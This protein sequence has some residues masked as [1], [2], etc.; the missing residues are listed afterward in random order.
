MIAPRISSI[1]DKEVPMG[2]AKTTRHS[3]VKLIKNATDDLRDRTPCHVWFGDGG[4]NAGVHV[5]IPRYLTEAEDQKVWD[6]FDERCGDD[7][8]DDEAY[9]AEHNKVEREL[10]R[11]RD[12]LTAEQAVE[13]LRSKYD[14]AV[15][16]QRKQFEERIS[17]FLETAAE[18]GADEL[19][20]EARREHKVWLYERQLMREEEGEA[21]ESPPLA[22]E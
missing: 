16:L 21:A 4:E 19:A 2:T 9:E 20:K 13:W 7:R 6:A 3:R 1:E 22:A 17:D 18:C 10:D 5:S 12:G 8:L 14:E 15:A 11:E